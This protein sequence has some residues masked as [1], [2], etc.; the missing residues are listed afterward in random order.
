MKLLE[1][2]TVFGVV[3]GLSFFTEHSHAQSGDRGVA[4]GRASIAVFPIA[5]PELP[6]V[7]DDV[8][9]RM[10]A[11]LNA[12][13]ATESGF[14]T[15]PRLAIHKALEAGGHGGSAGKKS[16]QEL[17]ALARMLEGE[18][19]RAIRRIQ[20]A[21]EAQDVSLE[22]H[23]A[24][25]AY[26]VFLAEE[27]AARATAAAKEARDQ[28]DEAKAKTRAAIRG[29]SCWEDDCR[30]RIAKRVGAS[31]TMRSTFYKTGSSNPEEACALELK[32]FHIQAGH[33]DLTTVSKTSCDEKGLK[34][35]IADVAGELKMRD[36]AGYEVYK[37]DLIDGELIKNPETSQTGT[38]KI[39]ASAEGDAKEKIEVWV[40]GDKRGILEN[41]KFTGELSYGRAIVVLKS[42]SDLF[43]SRRF[44]IQMGSTPIEIPVRGKVVLKPVYGSLAFSLVE[45][46]WELRS[47][48][49]SLVPKESNTVRPGEVPVQIFLGE[50]PLGQVNVKVDPSKTSVLEITARPK[51]KA[52]LEEDHEIWA[53]RKWSSLAGAAVFLGVG[54]E[55]LF[56]AFGAQDDR[57]TA[58]NS[59][60]D[61]NQSAAYQMFRSSVVSYD[62]TRET[63]QITAVSF[64][65]TAGAIGIWSGI[66]W[67]FLAPT[68]GEL[69]VTG[70][71]VTPISG[72]ADDI[73]NDKISVEPGAPR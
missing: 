14:L 35:A 55:R 29:G 24:R 20:S 42:V 43:A 5:A 53:W 3:L 49:Q 19:K 61:T 33:V 47:G 7:E 26:A 32:F 70:H 18:A 12:V 59:L 37:L 38:L 11:D 73:E 39:R 2:W 40:N 44:D 25:A 56:A 48:R 23:D 58:L 46:P 9:S 34:L 1:T 4:T 31:K 28:V 60:T 13:I 52:E 21:K 50:D 63:A 66:E 15:V 62:D 22:S 41:S 6:Q 64:L 10:T 67:L 57:T 68:P 36:K 8:L 54:T 17:E 71:K 27:T 72:M 45:G 65:V 30:A 51:T 16:V 69:K